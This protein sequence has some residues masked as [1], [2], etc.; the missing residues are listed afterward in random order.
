MEVTEDRISI[1]GW[2]TDVVS[3]DHCVGTSGVSQP[4]TLIVFIPGNPGVIHWYV[5]FLF[6]I[7]QT[8]GEGF[9]VRGVSYAGH[10]VG[11]DVVGTNEDHNTRM[12]S[13]QREN[14]GRRKMNVA[15]TMDGQVKHKVEWIDKIILEWNKNATIYEKSPTHKEFSSPKLIF[16]SHS[17]GAHLVQC[18]LLERPDILART[19][20]IIHLMPFFRF[21]PPLLK[22]ALLS[23]VAHNYR[24]TIPIMTAAVRCF[25]LTFPSR[26]I[27]LCMKKIAG[28][29][30]EKGRKIAMD[31]FLNPKMVKNH[32]VLG[33]QEVRELPEL[34]NVSIFTCFVNV[35]SC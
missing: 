27:E 34:P 32:L 8:L 9:A 25:S 33:T 24:M 35:S 11:D 30:C 7:L 18:L 21:D 23:T 3:I 22:K 14:Q 26:L 28:V 12:N 6:K 4:H 2:P 17:I 10:G 20:H 1:C 31:V 16:I 29:D 19:S 13:E 5:D 15:W